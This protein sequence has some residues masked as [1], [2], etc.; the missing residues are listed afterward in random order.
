MPRPYRN[1]S[2]YEKR[3]PAK[4]A[5]QSAVSAAVARGDLKR[6]PCQECGSPRSQGHHPDYAKPLEVLWLCQRHHRA[7]HRKHGPGMNGGDAPLEREMQRKDWSGERVGRLRVLRPLLV[8]VR[9]KDETWECLCECGKRASRSTDALR[10]ARE[11]CSISACDDCV[12]YFRKVAFSGEKRNVLVAFKLL[13]IGLYTDR[14][15]LQMQDEIT[16]AVAA[17]IGVRPTRGL[18]ADVSFTSQLSYSWGSATVADNFDSP[19]LWT[20]KVKASKSQ[21]AQWK[22]IGK[23][24]AAAR[25]AKRKAA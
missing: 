12:S 18:D 11:R 21:R 9:N 7:W 10:I 24:G 4:K 13:G 3:F 15:S 20:G 17:I 6:L 19:E 25:A 5:A 2:G 8:S 1:P 22:A 23:K 16:D 14:T